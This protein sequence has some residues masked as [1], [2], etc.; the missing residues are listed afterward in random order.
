M[1]RLIL[2]CLVGLAMA[3]VYQVLPHLDDFAG[4]FRQSGVGNEAHYEGRRQKEFPS[5]PSSF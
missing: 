3:G 2:F 4:A 1:R 5:V